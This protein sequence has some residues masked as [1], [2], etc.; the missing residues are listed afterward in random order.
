MNVAERMVGRKEHDANLR[1]NEYINKSFDD[2]WAAIVRLHVMVLAV[3]LI[4]AKKS[5]R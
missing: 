2:V 5:D 1:A 4:L 3:M